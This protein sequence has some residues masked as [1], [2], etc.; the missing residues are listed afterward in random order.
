MLNRN[1]Y[2][3]LPVLSF[4][5]T[6]RT[7][8]LH[9][10]NSQQKGLTMRIYGLLV[11]I[12]RML[13]EIMRL[14]AES[15]FQNWN[16]IKGITLTH[17][18]M[19]THETT[20]IIETLLNKTFGNTRI[21][22]ESEKESENALRLTAAGGALH[23]QGDLLLRQYRLHHLNVLPETRKDEFIASPLKEAVV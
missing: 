19:K 5:L 9:I 6:E 14:E 10:M 2:F 4:H 23:I 12:Q 13:E 3:S 1:H 8:D 21:Y 22:K 11:S 18:I 17:A 16:I 7:A 20:G 15:A